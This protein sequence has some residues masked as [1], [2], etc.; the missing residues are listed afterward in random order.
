VEHA[1]ATLKMQLKRL[2]GGDEVLPPASQM[3]K[4]LY[5]LNFLNCPEQGLTPTE[6]HWQPQEVT[7]KPQGL[8]KN[9]L[10]GKLHGPS[11]VPMWS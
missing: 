3:H 11:P 2:K 10:P 6:W 7:V 5:T 8:W 1:N 4:D 9:V